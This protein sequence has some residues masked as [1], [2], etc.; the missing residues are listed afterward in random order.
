MTGDHAAAL[1]A[2]PF[3]LLRL[4]KGFDALV[5]YAVQV[6]DLAHSE[7]RPVPLVDG[8]QRLTRKGGALIAVSDLVSAE[9]IAALLQERAGLVP[10][11]APDTVHHSNA[12]ALDVVCDCEIRCAHVAVHSARRD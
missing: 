3:L 2:S 11:P 5:P 9:Q 12:L 7:L 10:G 6:L 4:Q 8:G 1:R